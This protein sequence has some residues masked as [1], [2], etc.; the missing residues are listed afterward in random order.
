MWLW[1]VIFLSEKKAVPQ[2]ATNE[3]TDEPKCGPQRAVHNKKVGWFESGR[4]SRLEIL[5]TVPVY[6]SRSSVRQAK[7]TDKGKFVYA[8]I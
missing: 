4:T 2:W 3:G 5:P 7:K 8:Q 1:L 6:D